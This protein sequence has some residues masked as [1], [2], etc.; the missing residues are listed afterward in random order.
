MIYSHR[1][2]IFCNKTF[3]FWSAVL[4][5]VQLY[6]YCVKWGHAFLNAWI[7]LLTNIL[8]VTYEGDGLQPLPGQL[9][10]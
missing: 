9:L 5:C 2:F 7:N 6:L 1:L 8:T 4:V 3:C 10:G